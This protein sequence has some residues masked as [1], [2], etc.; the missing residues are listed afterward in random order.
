MKKVTSREY[1]SRGFTL[2]ELM[3]ALVVVGILASIALP[4]YLDSVRKSRRSDAVTALAQVQQAQ[5]R[6]RSNNAAYTTTL[7]S[8]SAGSV[9]PSGYYDISLAQAPGNP[10]PSLATAYVVMAY[11]KSELSQALDA[12]CRRIAVLLQSGNLSY[13]GCGTCSNFAATDFAPT[14]ACWAR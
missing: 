4:S 10:A 6:W 1:K 11:G 13:A 3:I 12:Q 9:S 7:A 5:E 8:L 14:H 2:I